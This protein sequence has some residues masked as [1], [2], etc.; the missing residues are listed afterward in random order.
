MF[1]ERRHVDNP[2]LHPTRL[3][4]DDAETVTEMRFLTGAL[5]GPAVVRILAE[6][7]DQAHTVNDLAVS[8]GH[9]AEQVRA[10]VAL[11]NLFAETFGFVPIIRERDDGY[12]VDAQTA[13]V[14]LKAF[15]ANARERR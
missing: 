2:A 8:S 11:V 14:V 6:Q 5:D 7:P 13:A 10:A 4:R 9:E 12:V 15:A 1:P 3:W